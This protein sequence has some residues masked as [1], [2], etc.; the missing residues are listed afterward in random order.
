MNLTEFVLV[1]SNGETSAVKDDE[2]SAGGAL[3]NGTDKAVLQIVCA[4]SL[5]LDERPRA[6][7]SGGFGDDG[8]AT[9]VRAAVGPAATDATGA[10]AV[11][12]AVRGAQRGHGERIGSNS[13]LIIEDDAGTQIR[14]III[15]TRQ[16]RET[17]E[18]TK[19]K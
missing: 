1:R 2:S 10:A 7:I 5:I 16:G 19:R 9:A 4:T 13:L 17:G 14:I 6:V 3:V 12:S 18:A 15:I 8:L 11:R